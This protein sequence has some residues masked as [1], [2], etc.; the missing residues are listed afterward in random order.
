MAGLLAERQKSTREV[1]PFISNPTLE[2]IAATM[3]YPAFSWDTI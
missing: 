1:S 3:R 2:I